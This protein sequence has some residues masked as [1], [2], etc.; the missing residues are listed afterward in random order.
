VKRLRE[1]WNT[2]WFAPQTGRVLGLYR[3]AIGLLTIYSFALWAKD[4]AVFFSD[5]GVLTTRTLASAMGREYH[6]ILQWF[7][8]PFTV[9][10]A[11]AAL[12]A[13]ALCFTVGWHTRLASITLYL[14]VVSFHERNNL[15]LNGG[16]TVL[17]TMLFFF[18]FAPAGAAFSVDALRR[19]LRSPD[20]PPALIS[21]WAQRMMQVQVAVIYFV[22]AYAKSRGALYHEGVAMYYIFGLVD[23]NV[24]GVEQLMNYP[25]AYSFLTYAVLLVEVAIPF[26]LWFRASRPYAIMMGIFAHGWIIVFMTIPVFG[27]LMIATYIPF[28]T[29]AEL[30]DALARVR[31]RLVR[32]RA[33]LYL[34]GACATCARVRALVGALDLFGRVHATDARG[35]PAESLPRGVGPSDV[36]EERIL[37]TARGRVL[38]GFDAWRWIAVR[39][40]ALAWSLPLWYL[41]GV[42][43]AGRRL[44][45]RF[46]HGRSA[47]AGRLAGGA[48]AIEQSTSPP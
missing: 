26:L 41:P 30:S 38:K 40:P 5:D 2:F 8:S 18:M 9:R 36:L 48:W 37:V 16:D 39:L 10:L 33:T 44:Y 43:F 1:D 6:T 15:V 25:L 34:D 23:F 31:R 45:R 13:A 17:R 11:L 47:P 46:A 3:V 4:V 35:V 12:F 32:R 19:R 27:I 24:R 28:F 20:A 42:A 14:L 22:T 7:G 21:P 29:E